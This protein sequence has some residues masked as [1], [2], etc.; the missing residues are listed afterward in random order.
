MKTFTYGTGNPAKLDHMRRMLAPLPVNITGAKETGAALPDVDE[1]GNTP[2]ENARIKALAYYEVLRCPVFACDSGL[3]IDG[4]P[5]DEQPGVHVRMVEGR[6][7]TDDEMIAHY[8]AIAKRLGGKAVARY[9]NAICLVMDD[10]EIYA[11]F[12]ED[13]ASSAFYI[14]DTPHAKR[15]EGFPLDC[16]SVRMDTG[17]YY[18]D[19]A[20][21]D[22]LGENSQTRGFQ[23]FFKRVLALYEKSIPPFRDIKSQLDH[24]IVR[25]IM[26]HCVFDGSPAGLDKEAENYRGHT[27]WQFY[28]WVE[29]GEIV[30]VC[31]F[32]VHADYVEILHIAVAENARRRGIGGKM[33]TALWEKYKLTIEAETDDDAVDFYRKT[34]FETTAIQKYNV[35][36]WT[37]VKAVPPGHETDEERRARIYPI[38]LSEYNPAWPQWYAEERDNL[39]R[40]LGDKI[41]RIQHIGSTA[42]PGLTAKPTV[43]ILLEVAVGTDFSK[44]IAAFSEPDYICLHGEG[45]TVSRDPLMVIKG[46]TDTGFA[47]RVFH[48]HVR[49]SGDYD[50][51]L[52]RD[53]L[54]AHPDS[55]AEYVALKLRL[56]DDFEHDRDGY[57]AAKGAFIA[58]VM[59]KARENRD[60]ILKKD[61]WTF[62]VRAQGI[63][64]R[65]GKVLL[66]R[67]QGTNEHAFPGGHMAFGEIFSE[68]LKREWLE[69][70]GA[71]IEVGA[72]QWVEENIYR[73]R[74]T[75]CQ[76]LAVSFLV[77]LTDER[78]TPL[79]GTFL[80]KEA[81]SHPLGEIIEFC[82]V[83]LEEV[84][85]I[86]VY[87]ERAAELL[88]R[89]GEGVEHIVYRED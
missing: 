8:A 72:L 52:F 74:D 88:A 44:I 22:T 50:E 54:I 61:G 77:T 82:W 48:I 55:A 24:P 32:E 15:V 64:V 85:N 51:P 65:E 58:A 71:D 33:V 70:V 67:P 2:P 81:G 45:L 30:G 27:Q 56:K 66:Q 42:V 40:I 36:R 4:L 29:N 63:L 69:E 75:M 18:Y 17:A 16:L 26:S 62:G 1:S 9:R 25:Q 11:H 84:Q 34:G 5:D 37:C 53:Y 87:P 13:I 31:G 43:D 10:G 57:T 7:L 60:I 38:I 23:A 80:S 6:R 19:N 28:G 35:Q 59:L 12:G 86:T 39:V 73:W 83:P 76:G 3:Y 79:D 89:L 49:E 68:T 41:V 21:D 78:Q 14:V 46:Y 20:Q 47:E